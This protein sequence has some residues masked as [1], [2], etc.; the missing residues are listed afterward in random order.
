MLRKLFLS[1]CFFICLFGRPVLAQVK[2]DANYDQTKKFI[3]MMA[4]LRGYYT[5]SVDEK[6]LVEDAIVHVLEELDPHSSFIT[7]A[8]V[9]RQEEPLVGN[10]DGVGITFQLFKDTIMVMDVI[11]GGPAQKVGILAGDKIVIVNDTVVAGIKITQQDVMRKLR[12]PKGTK[13]RVTVA[14]NGGKQDF[15]ITRDRIPIYSVDVS[16]MAAPGIGYI[17]LS[18]FA[19]TSLK[20]VYDAM[21]KLKAEG[22][23]RLILDLQDNTGGYLYTA[24]DL[25]SQF[26]KEKE[27]IVYTE[28]L[29]SARYPYY[30]DGRGSFQDGKFIV[31]IN[32]G[33]ASASE[34]VSG[35]VQDNDRGLVV[36]RR[37]WGKG[38]VQKPFPLSDGSQVRL[39]TAQYYTPSGRCI[40]RPYD[41][42]KKD[43]QDEYSRRLQSGELFG[44]D[45][46]H[47]ADSLRY[48]T[49]KMKRNVYGGGGVMPDIFVPLDTSSNS[50]LLTD[51]IRK[52]IENQFALAYIDRHRATLLQQYSTPDAFLQQFEADDS[53]MADLFR[54][55]EKDSVFKVDSLFRRSEKTLRTRIKALIGRNLHDNYVFWK[56]MNPINPVYNRAIELMQSASFDRWLSPPVEDKKDKKKGK[57]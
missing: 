7:A 37:S 25:C 6:K 28:G 34:I 12:G 18:R 1:F 24:V 49:L 16:Y 38:L 44:V 42:G 14:R 23:D 56:T 17:K 36:G 21:V 53:I 20:E 8:E 30:S 4:L 10:F 39:T 40:Q 41:K 47:F 48:Q 26:L 9:K 45:T 3:E 32:E 29:H 54:V 51:L 15:L 19:S 55:A 43:Y 52:G 35:C 33:S 2:T 50:S 13:V 5:D 46:F 22:M 11:S 31:L 57:K 27:L